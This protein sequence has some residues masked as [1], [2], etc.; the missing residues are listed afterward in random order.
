MA[1][2]LTAGNA[3]L[4]KN[5][6]WQSA[7]II[8]LGGITILFGII[9]K[10]NAEDKASQNQRIEQLSNQ[11]KHTETDKTE[12]LKLETAKSD[13]EIKRQQILIDS[14]QKLLLTRTDKNYEELKNILDIRDKN[15]T[16]TIKPKKK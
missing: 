1:I 9:I 16:I 15:S 12:W 3:K 10:I 8:L 6:P 7:L 14:L 2:K 4:L 13:T 5:F 11:I